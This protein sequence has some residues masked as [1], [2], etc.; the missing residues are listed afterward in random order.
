MG[1][2]PGVRGRNKLG[3]L[4]TFP[5]VSCKLAKRQGGVGGGV[6]F[7]VFLVASFSI[8]AGAGTDKKHL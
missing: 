2:T 1:K 5:V 7:F 4:K 8:N 3:Y 6:L